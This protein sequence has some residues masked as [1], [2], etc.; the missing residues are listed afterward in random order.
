MYRIEIDGFNRGDQTVYFTVSDFLLEMKE[1]AHGFCRFTLK[2]TQGAVPSEK[3][4][5]CVHLVS[6]NKEDRIIFRG[7]LARL[8]LH[9]TRYAHVCSAEL[10]SAS[11]ALDE[12]CHTRVFQ[13]PMKTPKDIVSS[14]NFSAEGRFSDHKIRLPKAG[15]C[16]VAGEKTLPFPVVQSETD[17]GFLGR[18]ALLCETH[19][20]TRDMNN[21]PDIV[22]GASNG[23]D[24]ITFKSEHIAGCR[25]EISFGNE[26]RVY[27]V[28][29]DATVAAPGT[30]AIFEEAADISERFEGIITAA[31]VFQR[32]PN[33]FYIEY[34][35]ESS[36]LP[37]V[38]GNTHGKAMY[39]AAKV[40]DNNDPENLGRV[41]VDFALDDVCDG[42][43]NRLWI[44]CEAQN[45][46]NS[47]GFVYVPA[48]GDCVYV[49]FSDGNMCVTGTA[50][51]KDSAR[52]PEDFS[53]VSDRFVYNINGKSIS[54]REQ[55]IELRTRESSVTLSDDSAE[56]L[57]G[58]ETKVFADKNETRIICGGASIKLNS[59]G[60]TLS[61][62]EKAVIEMTDGK[63]TV[64]SAVSAAVQ[65]GGI[66]IKAKDGIKADSG[67]VV[68]LKGT[69][70]KMN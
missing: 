64:D 47:G 14:L 53:E 50:R 29:P 32:S 24:R 46:S 44:G 66:T 52:L 69:Q 67:G 15:F 23:A 36:P 28:L 39:L 45:G 48:T 40:T 26:R 57:I 55:T 1:G 59:G 35:V 10:V 13:D 2:S 33:D 31:R 41:Q 42:A 63:I 38:S 18:I 70:I 51:E 27:T 8:E 30:P 12:V 43:E 34:T 16:G 62:G 17:F 11:A 54:L 22:I 3:G 49:R 6:E 37:A 58:G 5:L 7:V 68:S 56:M 61:V 20:W 25:R 65:S 19:L 60:I 21:I 9:R 4:I